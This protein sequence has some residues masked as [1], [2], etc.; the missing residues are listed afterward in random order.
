MLKKRRVCQNS[1]KRCH[2]AIPNAVKESPIQLPTRVAG[3]PSL[4]KCCQH[5][6]GGLP[7]FRKCCQHVLGGLPSLRKCCQ[8]VLGGLPSF[9]KC[10]Q[11]VLGGLPDPRM[12]C[13]HVLA[14]FFQREMV[15][16]GAKRSRNISYKRSR[17]PFNGALGDEMII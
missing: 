14:D 1:I 4:R 16:T 9:R 13:Q 11:H 5:V 3:L 2:F 6:L 7:S 15:K 17:R 10:C 8:H 12:A